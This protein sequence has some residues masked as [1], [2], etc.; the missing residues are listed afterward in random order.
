MFETRSDRCH[1]NAVVLDSDWEAEFARVAEAHPRVLAYVKNQGL[2][3]EVPYMDGTT[4]RRYRP[5]F[6]LRVDDGR[7][8]DDALHL[9]V[10]IQGF[11]RGDAQLKAGAMRQRWV[12]GVNKLGAYGRWNF[13]E[14][15]HVFEIDAEFAK[16]VE[17]L[18]AH[19]LQD[20]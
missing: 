13:A 9:V 2:Q 3:F 10:A 7:G 20:R 14:F 17:T 4:P 11:R 6:I 1:V 8:P 18:A 12:P 15:F 5:D 16:L 19:A